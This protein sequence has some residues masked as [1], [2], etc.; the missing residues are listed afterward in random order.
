MAMGVLEKRMASANVAAVR[1][2]RS[3]LPSSGIRPASWGEPLSE[4]AAADRTTLAGGL[5]ELCFLLLAAAF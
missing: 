2:L 1:A 4:A 3:L 5:E